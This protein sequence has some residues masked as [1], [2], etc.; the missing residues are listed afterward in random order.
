MEENIIYSEAYIIKILLMIIRH[1]EILE[2]I[3]CK[4]DIDNKILIKIASFKSLLNNTGKIILKSHMSNCIEQLVKNNNQD[5]IT[6]LNDVI[7]KILK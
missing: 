3:Y 2:N 1:A 5:S 7:E 6:K 4:E